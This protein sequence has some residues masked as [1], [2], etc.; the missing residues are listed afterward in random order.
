M[1]KVPTWTSHVC[2][3]QGVILPREYARSPPVV[4]ILP[5]EILCIFFLRVCLTGARRTTNTN[6]RSLS[7][8]GYRVEISISAM[9]TAN[10]L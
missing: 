6:R 7:V 4:S 10:K 2:D 3:V 8:V 5:S 1:S 9:F